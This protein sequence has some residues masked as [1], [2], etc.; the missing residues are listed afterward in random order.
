MEGRL[1]QLQERAEPSV[2]LHHPYSSGGRATSGPA[3]PPVPRGG[4]RVEDLPSDVRR[5]LLRSFIPHSTNFGFFLDGARF[6]SSHE[7]DQPSPA[8]SS[9]INLMGAYFSP[10]QELSSLQHDVLTQALQDASRGLSVNHPHRVLHTIQA[11]VLIAQYLFL[12]GRVLEGK[13]HIG[14]AV[15]LVLG[16]GFHKIRSGHQQAIPR[17]GM[18]PPMPRDAREEVER[19]NA[20]W[21]V[22]VLNDCWAAADGGP[23]NIAYDVPE[24]RVDSPWPLDFGGR[25]PHF[26]GNLQSGHTIQNFLANQPDGV[27]S[28]NA[29]HAKAA[30]LFEQASRLLRQYEPNLNAR[31][32]AK[33]QVTFGNLNTLIHRFV[34]ELPALS[35]VSSKA[36]LRRL[37]VIHT[38]ARVAAIQLHY[39]FAAQNANSHAIIVSNAETI[40]TL[41]RETN[42]SDFPFVDPIMGV[43]WT[44]TAKVFADEITVV[45]ARTSQSQRP[46][47]KDIVAAVEMIM[48]VMSFFAPHSPLLDSQLAQVRRSIVG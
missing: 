35:G 44:A 8:L 45:R 1:R 23:S 24:S 18:S 36:T 21:T 14:T 26:P 33:F 7:G 31:E 47:S 29:L 32:A 19:V 40:V 9:A 20:L 22:L 27:T 42:M 38:L 30:I 41:L 10:Q 15:S 17:S 13:Y 5:K 6:Q 43:L 16:A 37:L 25:E 46:P 12:N 48:S 2:A 11:E 34:S 39:I 3:S 4:L 28:L